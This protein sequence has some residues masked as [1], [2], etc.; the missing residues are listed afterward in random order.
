MTATQ[1]ITRALYLADLHNSDFVTWNDKSQSLFETY[2]DIYSSY[3][4]SDYDFFL[5][6]VEISLTPSMLAPNESS[7]VQ[8]YLVPLPSDF[9][10]LRWVDYSGQQVW[11]AM[12][13]FQIIDKNILGDRKS[14]V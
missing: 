11:Q 8:E 2:R 7:G 9:L 4:D 1:I 10:R 13:K 5:K 6:D 14:V 12:Q 3:V